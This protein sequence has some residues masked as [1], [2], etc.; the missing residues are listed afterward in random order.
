MIGEMEV[1]IRENGKMDYL[2]DLEYIVIIKI[3]YMKENGNMVILMELDYL[4]GEMEESILD[5][6]KMIKEMD[7]AF[8]FGQIH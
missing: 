1:N 5:I 8:F 7:L 2:M 3:E 6:L 4:N